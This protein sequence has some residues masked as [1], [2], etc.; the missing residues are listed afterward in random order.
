MCGSPPRYH[1][2]SV[3]DLIFPHY[4]PALCQYASGQT[5]YRWMP[6]GMPRLN[7]VLERSAFFLFRRDPKTGAIPPEPEGTGFIVGRPWKTIPGR[8][9]FYAVSNWHVV[10]DVGASILRINTPDGASRKIET[11]PHEWYFVTP[12]DDLVICDITDSLNTEGLYADAMTFIHEATFA[13]PQFIFEHD[14]GMGDD[15]FMVGLFIDHPGKDE[16]V[17][18]GRF[19]NISRL[20][21]GASLVEQ[22]NGQMGPSHLVDTRS[23]GGFSG[24]PVFVYRSPFTSMKSVEGPNR[25][26]VIDPTDLF[27]MLLGV[28]CAQ[29]PEEVRIKIAE[30]KR[31]QIEEGDILKIPSSLTVVVPAWEISRLMDSDTFALIREE[32]EKNGV[33]RVAVAEI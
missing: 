2:M 32:R 14:I 6:A 26:A 5:A 4:A 8:A 22:P 12:G 7:P 30:S 9:H 1:V 10:V 17:P 18:L 13:T 19:G 27:C 3:H 28:H 23:R 16:N 33:R 11:E 20:S 29:F 21:S 31:T 24:S 25:T 15:V